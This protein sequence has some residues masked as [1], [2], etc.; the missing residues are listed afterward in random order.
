[1]IKYYGVRFCKFLSH[2]SKK[3]YRN[4]KL[5]NASLKYNLKKYLQQFTWISLNRDIRSFSV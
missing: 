2:F 4:E 1:M 3:I 5:G